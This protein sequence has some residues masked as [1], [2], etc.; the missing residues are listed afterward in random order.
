MGIDTALVRSSFH[1]RLPPDPASQESNHLTI[2]RELLEGCHPGRRRGCGG[3]VVRRGAAIGGG[4]GRRSEEGRKATGAE[5]AGEELGIG[6][7]W[8]GNWE[9]GIAGY[10][11]SSF[12]FTA[13][14]PLA[15]PQSSWASVIMGSAQSSFRMTFVFRLSCMYRFLLFLWFGFG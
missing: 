1:V 13:A 8:V 5:D 2:D 4:K 10:R 9:L 11:L 15:V 14:P 12:F 6:L 7:R 3:A